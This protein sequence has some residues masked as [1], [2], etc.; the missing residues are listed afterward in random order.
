MLTAEG[1]VRLDE[2]GALREGAYY[3]AGMR[4]ALGICIRLA[5]VE[6][7]FER[8]KPVLVLD[9][10]FVDMDEENLS[11]ARAFLSALKQEYQIV[12]LTC[13]ESRLL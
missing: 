7:L 13:H 5:L 12:Y 6:T 4:A 3:S 9:D 10:P 11:L 8:E 2:A 1:E